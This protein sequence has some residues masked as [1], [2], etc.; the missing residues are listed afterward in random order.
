M[1]KWLQFQVPEL[2]TTSSQKSPSTDSRAGNYS[3][4]SDKGLCFGKATKRHTPATKPKAQKTKSCLRA[5]FSSYLV[6]LTP[7]P[8][9]PTFFNTPLPVLTVTAEEYPGSP[10]FCLNSFAYFP[11][12]DSTARVLVVGIRLQ[13]SLPRPQIRRPWV[14]ERI[15]HSVACTILWAMPYDTPGRDHRSICFHFQEPTCYPASII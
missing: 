10:L 4:A 9:P 12:T 3:K 11:S 6:T 7:P 13:P 8:I 1:G 2:Q 5:V 15:R 14:F